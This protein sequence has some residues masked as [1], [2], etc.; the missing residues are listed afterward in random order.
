ML[1]NVALIFK[2]LLGFVNVSSDVVTDPP[3]PLY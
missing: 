3:L 2:S 1:L